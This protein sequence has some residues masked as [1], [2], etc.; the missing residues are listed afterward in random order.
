MY[1]V[2]KNENV[3]EIIEETSFDKEKLN[4]RSNIQEWIAKDPSILGY[5]DDLMVI[6]KEYDGFEKTN[7]RLDLLALS[8]DGHLV[9]IENKR[10][11]SGREVVAQV[12]MYASFCST[13]TAEQVVDLY[14]DYTNKEYSEAKEE[15][16]DF[17]ETDD[18]D[19]MLAED[20]PK[21]IIVSRTFENEVLSTAQWL[22]SK[23]LD[24][25]CIR[26]TPY[27]FKGDVFIDVDRILPQDELK[28]FSIRVAEKNKENERN[29]GSRQKA[30]IRNLGFWS[31]FKK[32]W[33]KVGSQ[34]YKYTKKIIDTQMRNNKW[35]EINS[36]DIGVAS[37]L[38]TGLSYIFGLTNKNCSV[39]LYIYNLK[40]KE[41][42]KNVYYFLESHKS[43]IENIGLSGGEWCWEPLPDKIASRI[44]IKHTIDMRNPTNWQEAANFMFSAM[45]K[46]ISSLSKYAEETNKLV[47]TSNYEDAEKIE[48]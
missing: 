11:K 18:S 10:D 16:L 24:I 1:R 27:E 22:N 26:L 6:Q 35:G 29:E 48:K 40:S 34:D 39:A 38:G 36:C 17:L 4:E 21:I 8:K 43:D 13:L 14:K 5:Q 30:Q 37:G 41:I 31:E 47:D 2:N 28:D 3:L 23:G 44:S 42:N 20:D 25:T 7:M 15:I 19:I 46:L 33:D 9:V 45:E 32:T 12:L